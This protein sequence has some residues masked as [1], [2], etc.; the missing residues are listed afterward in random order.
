MQSC[1]TLEVVLGLNIQ[2]SI[3]VVRGLTG[4]PFADNS[5]PCPAVGT[6]AAATQKVQLIRQTAETEFS[7]NTLG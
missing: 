5:L 2:L 4:H 3:F 6:G 7:W 1:L